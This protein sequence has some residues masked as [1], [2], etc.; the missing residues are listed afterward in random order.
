MFKNVSRFKKV[1]AVFCFLISLSILLLLFYQVVSSAQIQNVPVAPNDSV[2]TAKV[3]EYSILNS[4]LERIEPEQVLYSLRILVISSQSVNGK[5][6]FTQSKVDEVI[7][8]YS[9]EMLSPILFDNII[10]ANV[11]LLGDERNG[12]YWIRDVK[13]QPKLD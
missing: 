6:N 1:C 12:R 10:K 4:I 13:F 3:L 8:V 7:K 11:S 5:I 9:K 2:V